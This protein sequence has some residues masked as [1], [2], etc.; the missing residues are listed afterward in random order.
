[1]CG[2]ALVLGPA[3]S[4]P[5]ANQTARMGELIAHR[6]PDDSGEFREQG[7]AMVFRRLSIFDL[8]PSGHQPMLSADARHVIV[9]NGA[10][11]N[12]IELRAELAAFGHTFRSTGDTEVLLAAY[13]QWGAGCLPRLNGMWAFAIYDRQTRRVFAARDRFGIKP[14]FWFHDAR[15][16]V[17]TSEI[18]TLRDSGYARLA[19]NWQTIAAFLLEDRLDETAD[20]FYAGVWRVPAGSYFETD[21]SAPPTFQRYWNIDEAAETLALPSDPVGQFRDVFDDS[22]RLRMRSD[23][24]VGVLLSG[25]LDST[26]IIS[27]MAAQ[28]QASGT[29]S[30]VLGALCYRDP[31]YDETA[32]VDETLRQTGASLW[33]LEANPTQFWNSLDRHLWHQDEPVHSFTSVVIYE[34]MKLARQHGVKVILNGQGA[35]EV[36]A[37]YGNYFFT[38]W[39]ELVRA[40]HPWFAHREM[41]AFAH[42]HHVAASKV[43]LTVLRGVLAY[44]KSRM[45]GYRQMADARNRARLKHNTWVS[46]DVKRHWR[47]PELPWFRTL[48]EHLRWS[49]E[50]ASLPLYLRVEDRNS[51]AHAI[52]VRLPFLD[53]RL[54]ALAFRLGSR[55]KL[56]EEY[57]K[58]LLR[59]AMRGRISEPVR[60]QVHKLGFPTSTD[61]WFRGELF[62]RCKDLLASR[63][64][65][66]SGIWNVSEI[67][68]SLERHKQGTQ[69]VGGKL[70]DVVQFTAWLA[71]SK[72]VSCLFVL[73][74]DLT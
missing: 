33:P 10:I 3:G 69:R 21:G 51:M 60:T 20:T 54:V 41:M 9:F 57:S 13:R 52:E 47:P 16:L 27:G 6:G 50:R 24:P 44:V 64:L 19:P 42:H 38:Y 61:G 71:L 23:V 22:I 7:L 36:L 55:W 62:E 67:E 11:Y 73:M 49:V 26:S 25:G 70:F 45:P 59:K 18:K 72:F 28:R 30:S 34:L 40:G 63:S 53:Y 5:D 4:T 48:T 68:R 2:F 1:M 29:Q 46:E 65:R 15:G 56:R 43:H 14:L 31:Q 32:L 58:V 74:P 39:T 66:E 8:A 37:G 12:F 17:L 35:D